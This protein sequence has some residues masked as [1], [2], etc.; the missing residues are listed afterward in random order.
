[1]DKSWALR[2]TTMTLLV[3]FTV[4]EVFLLKEN[5]EGTRE[6]G[7]ACCHVRFLGRNLIKNAPL[8]IAGRYAEV[9]EFWE[10]SLDVSVRCKSERGFGV[11][12]SSFSDEIIKLDVIDFGET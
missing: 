10:N 4:F 8:P 6:D 5:G 1:M 2:P 12:T 3:T 11:A 9:Q 7:K